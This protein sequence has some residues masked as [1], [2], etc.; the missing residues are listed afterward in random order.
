MPTSLPVRTTAKPAANR[1]D[2]RRGAEGIEAWAICV[3]LAA[4]ILASFIY[5][6]SGDQ[7]G[8]AL[9]LLLAAVVVLAMLRASGD[10]SQI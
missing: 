8:A 5:F 1:K 9:I 2:V 7:T 3:G 4:T 10:S 6:S